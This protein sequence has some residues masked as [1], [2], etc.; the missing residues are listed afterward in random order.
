MKSV[1]E[2]ISK[3]TQLAD[4]AYKQQILKY[5]TD[6]ESLVTAKVDAEVKKVDKYNEKLQHY[7]KKVERL[8]LAANKK[9]EAEQA[10]AE[11]QNNGEQGKVM[12]PPSVPERMRARLERNEDKLTNAW[13]VHERAAS[14]LCNFLEEATLQGW[15]DAY[16]FLLELIQWEVERCSVGY[17]Q[18]TDLLSIQDSITK[19]YDIERQKRNRILEELRFQNPDL[20]SVASLHSVS[21]SESTECK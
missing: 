4:G 2:R 14:A 16:P 11:K 8:R 9:L 18:V 20:E 1:Y 15:N 3:D 6:W 7:T 5:V 10:K 12:P 21:S 13:K 19:T 17:E